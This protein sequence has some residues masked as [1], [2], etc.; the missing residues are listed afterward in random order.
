MHFSTPLLSTRQKIQIRQSRSSV[1]SRVNFKTFSYKTCIVKQ[2]LQ[3]LPYMSNQMHTNLD[4]NANQ[5]LECHKIKQKKD[6]GQAPRGCIVEPLYF[7][8][9]KEHNFKEGSIV[10]TQEN[11]DI[12]TQVQE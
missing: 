4:Q 7:Q 8:R 3:M 5:L 10:G 6:F 9:T 11:F 12:I 2:G 1:L